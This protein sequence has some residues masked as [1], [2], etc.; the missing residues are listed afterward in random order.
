MEL[1]FLLILSMDKLHTLLYRLPK[2]LLTILCS[3][4]IIWLTLAPHPLGDNDLPLFP[5]ADKLAHALMFGGLT[6]CILLDIR[7]GDGWKPLSCKAVVTAILSAVLLG[8]LTEI[9]QDAMQ[10]GRGGDILDLA[11]DSAGSIIIAISYKLLS[12]ILK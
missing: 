1:D 2:W 7:R 5:G 8:A 11:A 4:A 12:P 6:F 10:L 9:L 3:A